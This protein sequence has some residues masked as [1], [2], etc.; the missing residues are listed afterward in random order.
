MTV[1]QWVQ[2]W[3][4]WR[5]VRRS[6]LTVSAVGARLANTLAL[7]AGQDGPGI[8]RARSALA[9]IK[10]VHVLQQGPAEMAPLGD[11][12]RDSAH[13]VDDW[14]SLKQ[15]QTTTPDFYQGFYNLF[16]VSLCGVDH[17]WPWSRLARGCPWQ[18][19]PSSCRTFCLELDPPSPR[20]ELLPLGPDRPWPGRMT[21]LLPEC[22][23]LEYYTRDAK[24]EK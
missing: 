4:T 22:T 19:R 21:S 6:F 2:R 9:S 23:S 24:G 12:T 13:Q 14:Q 18:S 17:I 10:L 1:K 15:T 8:V 11:G 20:P 7:C 5:E 3:V 16:F